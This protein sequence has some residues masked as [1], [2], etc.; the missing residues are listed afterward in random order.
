VIKLLSQQHWR[1]LEISPENVHVP[2]T[3]LTGTSR[4]MA[5]MVEQEILSINLYRS[6]L[7]C[8]KQRSVS[9]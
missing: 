2:C 6:S 4:W 7:T 5:K 8:Y 1:L 9:H 3:F